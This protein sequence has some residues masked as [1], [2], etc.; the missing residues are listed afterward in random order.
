MNTKKATEAAGSQQAVRARCEAPGCESPAI[1]RGTCSPEHFQERALRRRAAL[2]GIK[3][4][5]PSEPDKDGNADLDAFRAGAYDVV[6]REAVVSSLCD[7]V[8]R[9]RAVVARMSERHHP[10]PSADSPHAYCLSCF[11]GR[12]EVGS[13]FPEYH[14]WP[15]PDGIALEGGAR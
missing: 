6:D 9:L 7:E 2:H 3:I 4:G 5:G 11:T 15:C 13:N 10:Y 1:Y 12:K 8:Q 14:P